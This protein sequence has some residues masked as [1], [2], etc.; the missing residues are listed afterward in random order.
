MYN[1][2]LI[3]KWLKNLQNFTILSMFTSK[4]AEILFVH[5]LFRKSVSWL[6]NNFNKEY[7]QKQFN[8]ANGCLNL[9]E[10][11]DLDFFWSSL[12]SRRFYLFIFATVLQDYSW[13]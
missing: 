6:F 13:S 8:Q 4:C 9:N 2:R 1:L 3:K 5:Y 11:F 7:V 10:W 12:Q